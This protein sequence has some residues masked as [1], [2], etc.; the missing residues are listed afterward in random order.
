MTTIM[1]TAAGASTPRLLGSRVAVTIAGPDDAVDLAHFHRRNRDHL[2]PWL[3]PQP[4]TIG[5]VGFCRVWGGQSVR[6]YRA[7]A[8]ARFLIRLRREAGEPLIGQ[9][10]L[11]AIQRGPFQAATLGYHIDLEQEGRG[12]MR[13]A[14]ELVISHGFGALGLHRIM[15]NYIPS[16]IRSG[17]LLERLGFEREGYARDYLFI[18]GAWRDHVLTAL[19]NPSAEPPEL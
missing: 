19:V 17:A 3:P 11:N 18:D 13:E 1:Q 12:L 7:G 8:A 5:T 14:L 9:A 2:S 10:N 6:L 4:A 16:N 15:A